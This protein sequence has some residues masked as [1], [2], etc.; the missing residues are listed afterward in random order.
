LRT[1]VKPSKKSLEN[2][3]TRHEQFI[4]RSDDRTT[5][6]PI[7]T[8][9]QIDHKL[10]SGLDPAGENLLSSL[11][12]LEPPARR[13]RR[14]ACEAETLT[15]ASPSRLCC[16]GDG[17]TSPGIGRGAPLSTRGITGISRRILIRFMASHSVSFSSW[18]R[19]EN[20]KGDGYH[21]HRLCNI[22][23]Q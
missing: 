4:R 12:R 9:F 11:K 15:L 22:E 8:L 16:S 17:M 3:R 5:N 10:C 19:R 18:S 20:E 23:G 6:N 1:C 7:Q 14:S 13:L 2:K 21:Y